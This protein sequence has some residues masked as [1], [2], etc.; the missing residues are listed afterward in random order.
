MSLNS[1]LIKLIGFKWGTLFV[2]DIPFLET[3]HLNLNSFIFLLN[4][5]F[6]ALVN[7][8]KGISEHW[9]FSSL[10][11][12]K[13]ILLIMLL[14]LWHFFLNFVPLCPAPPLPPTFAHLSSC[15]WVVHISSL[16]STFPTL[17]LTSPCLSSTYHL[18]Y[19]FPVPFPPFSPPSPLVTFHVISSSVILFQF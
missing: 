17:F 4:L 3:L 14:K 10:L 9:T 18:C 19:L 16:A 8:K 13:Y 2:D 15:P 11:F 5:F 6:E 7:K 1:L 12:K